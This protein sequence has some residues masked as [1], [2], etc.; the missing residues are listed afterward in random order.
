ML[1][2]PTEPGIGLMGGILSEGLNLEHSGLNYCGPSVAE[3]GFQERWR[4][5]STRV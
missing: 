3:G 2:Y 1:L 4:G 5:N